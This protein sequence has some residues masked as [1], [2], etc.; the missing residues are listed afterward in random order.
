MR[1]AFSDFFDK[2]YWHVLDIHIWNF[3]E[4]LTYDIVSFEQPGQEHYLLLKAV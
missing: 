3:N 1:E 4:M 2:K